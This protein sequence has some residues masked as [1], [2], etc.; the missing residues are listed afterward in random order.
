MLHSG[1]NWPV[2]RQ[3]FRISDEENNEG[4]RR[5]REEES[6]LTDN[7]NDGRGKCICE[8][9]RFNPNPRTILKN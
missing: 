2:Q 8:R 7:N 9:E 1:D 4:R 5:E 3:G 6:M